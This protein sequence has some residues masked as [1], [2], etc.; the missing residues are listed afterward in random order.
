VQVNKLLKRKPFPLLSY[1]VVIASVA[2][3]VLVTLWLKP[4]LNHSV[5][6]LFFAAVSFSAWDGG[7]KSGL[8]ATILSVIACNYFF[9][10]SIYLQKQIRP[11]SLVLILIFSLVSLLISGLNEQ[12][13]VAKKSADESLV[14]AKQAGEERDQLLERERAARE[15]AVAANRVKDE[16]LAVLSHELRSPLNSILG[17]SKLLVERK[18]DEAT[19]TRALQIIERNAKLQA[20]LIEDLLDISRILQGKMSLKIGVVNLVS[21]IE[22]AIEIV[23]LAAQAKSIE[24]KTVYPL[25]VVQVAGDYNRLQQVLWNLLS[26]AVKFTPING[27]VEVQLSAS[28]T[29]AQIQISDTGQGIQPN[30]L[31]YVFDYFRQENSTTTRESGGLGLGLAIVRH[32]V[33]L[34]GGTVTAS[35]PGVGLGSTFI[36]T[37]P[38][39]AIVSDKTEKLDVSSDSPDFT[40]LKV[41]V[42]DDD[43]DTRELVVFILEE[44][45]AT[46]N[47]VASAQQVLDVLPSWQPDLLISDIGMPEMDGYM[48]LR[49]LRALPVE[50]GGQIPAIALT[51]YAQERDFQHMKQAGFTRYITKPVD[52]MVLTEVVAELIGKK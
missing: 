3:A 14:K 44:Y 2:L 19:T 6:I 25:N 13:R 15:E 47:H 1:G 38:L 9:L 46:V 34:H 24:I 37:F 4:V 35:S 30:F 42:V 8:L 40:S 17:W 48:L 51:A 41:L 45:G 10:P 36:V 26:N 33:E 31:P 20:E 27:H 16:F 22:A 50:K 11:A 52:P 18:Y 32:I 7:L 39:K 29:H 49:Q 23:R 43:L 28:D 21:P 5:F 12:L